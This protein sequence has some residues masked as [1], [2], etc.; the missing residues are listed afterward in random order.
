MINIRLSCFVEMPLEKAILKQDMK[1]YMSS[2]AVGYVKGHP[3]TKRS[4]LKPF[5]YKGP[6]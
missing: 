6:N 5:K 2:R 4:N 3:L 1:L